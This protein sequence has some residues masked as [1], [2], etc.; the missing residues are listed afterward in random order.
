MGNT[1]KGAGMSSLTLSPLLSTSRTLYGPHQTTMSFPFVS[2]FGYSH[3]PLLNHLRQLNVEMCMTLECFKIYE[4]ENSGVSFLLK[5]KSK[6]VIFESLA[7][8]RN[9]MKLWV[10]LSIFA[11]LAAIRMSTVCNCQFWPA[12]IS[13]NI[14]ILIIFSILFRIPEVLLLKLQK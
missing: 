14:N 4:R 6:F 5:R 9:L 3:P 11:F 10:F 7:L 1:T 2:I 8:F 13:Q 12:K